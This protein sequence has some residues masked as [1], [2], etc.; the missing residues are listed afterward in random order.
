MAK[1]YRISKKVWGSYAART[2]RAT[3]DFE[4]GPGVVVPKD[5]A[6]AEL[7]EHL[8]SI[9]GAEIVVKTALPPE[10][11]RPERPAKRKK[12]EA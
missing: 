2:T 1:S 6:E 9:A 5:Q 11:V 3:V 7:L 4:Y 12:K 10:P 8:V